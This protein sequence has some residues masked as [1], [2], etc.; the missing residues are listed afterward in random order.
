[1]NAR[2]GFALDPSSREQANEKYGPGGVPRLDKLTAEQIEAAFGLPPPGQR[3]SAG[4]ARL[5]Q[6]HLLARI[7]VAIDAM[8]DEA[9]QGGV[10]FPGFIEM[11]GWAEWAIQEVC[12]DANDA[13][14]GRG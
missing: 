6:I 4:R 9:I 12:A 5:R 11:R 3:M 13:M 1:M 8:R 7:I 2:Q 10:R 14:G